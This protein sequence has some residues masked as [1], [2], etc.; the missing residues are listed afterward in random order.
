MMKSVKKRTVHSL[1]H[2]SMLSSVAL[3]I[4][5]SPLRQ[6]IPFAEE[7]KKRGVKIYHLNIG[8]PDIKMPQVMY[9]F[10]RNW[11]KNPVPY[12]HSQGEPALIESLLWYYQKL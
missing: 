10:L 6:F 8:D 7:A 12:S 9:D 5:A 11:D 1:N 3:N 2:S 4:P